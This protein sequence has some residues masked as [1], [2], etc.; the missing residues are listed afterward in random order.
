MLTVVFRGPK[1]GT[2]SGR[3]IESIVRRVYGRNAIVRDS[4]DPNYPD[5]IGVALKP[6]RG[7]DL[8]RWDGY[9]VVA[10][11]WNTKGK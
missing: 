7:V 2:Y 4:H 1:A 6:H 9:N 10:S 11:I 8:G 5:Y 3:T